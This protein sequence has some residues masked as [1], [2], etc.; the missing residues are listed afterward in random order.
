MRKL[1]IFLLRKPIFWI[2]NQFSS[3]PDKEKIY[4]ALTQLYNNIVEKPGE[5]G[6][7]INFDTQKDKFIIFSDQHKGRRNG[8]DD[9]AQSEKNYIEAL[10][11]YNNQEFVFIN[12]GD[13][14]ELWENTSFQVIKNNHAYFIISN[15]LI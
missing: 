12:L 4:Q 15:V 5:K 7:T 6:F 9:F 2:N 8:A 10:N 14:E 1:F 11:Y 13:G 3:K